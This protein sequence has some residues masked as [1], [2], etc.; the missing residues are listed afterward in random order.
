MTPVELL[1]RVAESGVE[2]LL[3]GGQLTLRGPA[4]GVSIYADQVR[5]HRAD[6]IRLFTPA[7]R[8]LLHFDAS[9]REVTFDPPVDYAG[10]LAL[11]PDAV[12][13]EP[14]PELPPIPDCHRCLHFR[15]PGLSLGYC[16]SPDRTDLAPAYALLRVLPADGGETCQSFALSE[17]HS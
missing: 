16:G 2:V 7:A 6:I 9:Q 8:W 13:A 17:M 15:R 14:L 5:Q 3:S 12:A 1:S 10:A 4:E 11:Y